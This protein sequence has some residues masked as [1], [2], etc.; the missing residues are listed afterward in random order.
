MAKIEPSI[1]NKYL[2]PQDCQ[3]AAEE[4]QI[5]QSGR[6][7]RSRLPTK[8]SSILGELPEI[9]KTSLLDRH[10]YFINKLNHCVNIF[11]SW[12]IN[13]PTKK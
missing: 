8:T 9:Y 10:V 4:T 1:G 13:K 7:A 6:M 5:N 2:T 12:V 11:T 3:P